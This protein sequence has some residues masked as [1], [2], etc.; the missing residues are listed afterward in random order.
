MQGADL[1]RSSCARRRTKCSMRRVV[2]PQN[3]KKAV[4]SQKEDNVKGGSTW[5]K[6]SSKNTK[7]M[8]YTVAR[9]NRANKHAPLWTR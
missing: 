9:E 5:E 7:N 2:D 8:K 1:G 4:V 6:G 3:A